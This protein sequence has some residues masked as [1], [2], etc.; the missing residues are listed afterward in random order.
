MKV[1]LFV[2]NTTYANWY[3]YPLLGLAYLKAVLEKSGHECKIF[4]PRFHRWQKEELVSRI[5]DFE[6]DVVGV[7]A[8]THEITEAADIASK[9]KKS[10][11]NVP[12]ILGGCHVTALPERTIEEFPVFDVGVYEE[13]EKTFPELLRIKSKNSP[14]LDKIAGIVFQKNG[15]SSITPAREYLSTDELDA[16]PYPALDDYY[17]RNSDALGGKNS[18]YVMYASRGCPFNCAFCMRVLGRKVRQRSPES[19]CDE[20]LYAEN[21]YGAHTIRFR[22]EIFLFNN[23]RTVRTLELMVKLGIPKRLRWSGQIRVDFVETSLIRLAKKAGCF[24]L[25]MGVESGDDNILKNVGRGYT[26][27]KVRKAVCVIK[28]EEI[29]LGTYFI[30]GHPNETRET[31]KKTVDLVAEL[32]TNTAAVGL[33]VPYPGTRIYE[34]AV[35]GKGGYRLLSRN[36]ADYDKYNSRCLELESLSYDELV[37]WQK[38]AT[39]NFYLKNCRFWDM[40]KY[41]WEKR[42]GIAIMLLS[43]QKRE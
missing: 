43:G 22:D 39:L 31:V 13:G 5:V 12:M 29:R 4:D 18:E 1:S 32:N 24:L 23:D 27:D 3:H 6:P 17:P 40:A 2:P 33:M 8:M 25:G 15:Q 7:S 42:R 11:P 28:K 37:K 30:L 35:N 10:L 38:Y 14:Q 36:W 34:M 16:L 9:I 19:I 20:M 26:V 21:V 41:I